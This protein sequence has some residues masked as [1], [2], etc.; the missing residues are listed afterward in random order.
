MKNTLIL[1]LPLLFALHLG[2]QDNASTQYFVG[3][4][5]PA[6]GIVF[7]VSNDDAW[8]VSEPLG[9]MTWDRAFRFCP[10]YHGGGSN[11]WYLPTKDELES[12]YYNLVKKG[13]LQ[14]TET[15]WS[16]NQEESMALWGYNFKK[17]R[18]G[19]YGAARKLAV[20]AVRHFKLD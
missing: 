12:I 18:P 8:E 13:L 9:Q 4:P 3:G 11:D 16:S 10:Q 5:G 17:G 15:Y 6:G 19:L 14:D 7:A 1:I 2:A 20:R